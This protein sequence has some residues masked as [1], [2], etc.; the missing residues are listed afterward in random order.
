MP[1]E[2]T[3]ADDGLGVLL[4]GKGVVEGRDVVDIKEGLV[5]EIERLKGRS[6]WLVDFTEVNELRLSGDHMARLIEID[7]QIAAII[8]DCVVGLAAASDSVYGFARMW[9]IKAEKIGWTTAVFRDADDAK[10]WIRSRLSLTKQTS[11]EKSSVN[12]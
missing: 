7:N 11:L 4:V 5:R 9:E 10:L 6:Y 8:P 2:L 3:F 12:L 1:V